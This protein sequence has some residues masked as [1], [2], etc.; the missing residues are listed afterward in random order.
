MQNQSLK[1]LSLLI[2]FALSTSLG[3]AETSYDK[4]ATECKAK[5]SKD[6]YAVETATFCVNAEAMIAKENVNSAAHVAILG[7]LA[8]A[9][10]Y[11]KSLGQNARRDY[12]VKM[13]LAAEAGFGKTSAETIEPLMNLAAMNMDA[14]DWKTARAE[15]LEALVASEKHHG[16]LSERTGNVLSSLGGSYA[17]EKRGSPSTYKLDDAILVQKRLAENTEARLGLKDYNTGVQ[18]LDLGALTIKKGD[19]KEAK[20]LTEKALQILIDGKGGGWIEIAKKQLT[21]I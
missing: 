14:G 13:L 12:Y 6:T 1:K 10:A 16:V 19:K 8:L 15:I 11:N 21:N 18:W 4:L 17:A 20:R 3:Y 7:Q 5:I 9:S 2:I